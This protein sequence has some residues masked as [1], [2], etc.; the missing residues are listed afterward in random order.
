MPNENPTTFPHSGLLPPSI[1]TLLYH[2]FSASITI[3][4]YIIYVLDD[5]LHNQTL[6][7]LN[8]LCQILNQLCHSRNPSANTLEHILLMGVAAEDA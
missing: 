7:I 5:C 2:I 4:E 6:M 3:G 8:Q 1:F